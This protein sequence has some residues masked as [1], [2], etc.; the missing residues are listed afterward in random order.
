MPD[1]L[2]GAAGSDAAR[3]S[4]YD[5][6]V[7]NAEVQVAEA[8]KRC[9]G[10]RWPREATFPDDMRC[11]EASSDSRTEVDADQARQER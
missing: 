10:F 7:R 9:G 4:G 5:G 11:S 1:D 3:D 2:R 6:Y 8:F